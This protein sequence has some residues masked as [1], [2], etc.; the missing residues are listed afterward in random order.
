MQTYECN[1]CRNV[2]HAKHLHCSVCGTIPGRYSITRKEVTV[3]VS[4][5]ISAFISTVVA[6]GAERQER[7]RTIK[8]SLRTVP[9]DYYAEAE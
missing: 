3:K 9:L 8:R 7:N 1:I 6:H 5:S 4:A 2:N